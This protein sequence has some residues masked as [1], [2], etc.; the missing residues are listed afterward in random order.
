MELH[1]V[2]DVQVRRRL[3][4]EQHRRVL[5]ERLREDGAASFAA[6]ELVH[7]P[8]GEVLNAHRLHRLARLRPVRRPATG[9]PRQVRRPAHQH[10]PEDVERERGTTS[11]GTTATSRAASFADIAYGSRPETRTEPTG[12]FKRPGR[13]A[14]QRRLPA[15]VRTDQAH[16]L[17]GRRS[18]T[19]EDVGPP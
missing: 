5:R 10:E 16:D 9:P 4:Q 2:A 13:D 7:R 12:G 1:D 3:V 14:H 6:G 17:A 11:C 19:H 15:P 8:V 18:D